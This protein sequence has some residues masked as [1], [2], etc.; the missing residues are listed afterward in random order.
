MKMIP[1]DKGSLGPQRDHVDASQEHCFLV[2]VL[3]SL[4]P[5]YICRFLIRPVS[6]R[7][8]M[9]TTWLSWAPICSLSPQGLLSDTGE[10]IGF[11]QFTLA[12]TS[13]SSKLLTHEKGRVCA[14]TCTQASGAYLATQTR[15]PS[16]K[17]LDLPGLHHG[18][19]TSWSVCLSLYA[20][21]LTDGPVCEQMSPQAGRYDKVISVGHFKSCNRDGLLGVAIQFSRS[22]EKVILFLWGQVGDRR[23][24]ED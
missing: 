20:L 22:Q 18:P 3:S 5:Q 4:Y 11:G 23:P 21:F 12:L 8:Q 16:H 14:Q 19:H 15:P 7:K 24:P 17:S 10:S 13:W 1:M 9:E 2:W 6:Q